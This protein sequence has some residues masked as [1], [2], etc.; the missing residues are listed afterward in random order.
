MPP[1]WV[2]SP[3]VGDFGWKSV[4]RLSGNQGLEQIFTSTFIALIFSY[5]FLVFFSFVFWC[6]FI[7]IIFLIQTFSL[8]S[9]FYLSFSERDH[10]L[11]LQ[12]IA[13]K[14][15]PK[16]TTPSHSAAQ[17]FLFVRQE[18]VHLSSSTWSLKG[19]EVR[20]E[21]LKLKVR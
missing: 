9:T 3:A 7:G 13:Q 8:A 5:F 10:R 12:N 16:L 2:T 4:I 6:H 21:E 1:L 11:T 14:L 18:M 19:R 17:L 15:P 20:G